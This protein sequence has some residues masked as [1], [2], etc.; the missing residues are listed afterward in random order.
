MFTRPKD[1]AQGLLKAACFG[2][3][4]SLIGTFK[5]FN[6]SNGARGVGIATNETVVLSSILILVSD[7]FL[8]AMI[9]LLLYGS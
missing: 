6:T 8:S 5:G 9:R 1:I 7:Y 2:L 4:F 3:I